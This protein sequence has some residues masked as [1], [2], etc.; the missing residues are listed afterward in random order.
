M[1]KQL[2]ENIIVLIMKYFFSKANTGTITRSMT[3]SIEIVTDIC[4]LELQAFVTSETWN[5][6]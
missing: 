2:Q 4:V 3:S 6:I 5:M 1:I